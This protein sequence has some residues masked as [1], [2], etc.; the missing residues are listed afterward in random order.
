MQKDLQWVQEKQADRK[1]LKKQNHELQLRLSTMEG[2]LRDA[3][4]KT[5]ALEQSSSR[6]D[7]EAQAQQKEGERVKDRL[8]NAL[9][10]A[11]LQ[12]SVH[13]R[14]AKVACEEADTEL[15]RAGEL[16]AVED[17]HKRRSAAQPFRCL[18]PL[19][20]VSAPPPSPLGA[21]GDASN[22]STSR[23]LRRRRRSSTR[24]SQPMR[25]RRRQQR[26]SRPRPPPPRLAE[27][28]SQADQTARLATQQLESL[29]QLRQS[30]TEKHAKEVLERW[31]LRAQQP[32]HTPHTPPPTTRCASDAK[33]QEPRRCNAR[34]PS[35]RKQRRR[36]PPDLHAAGPSEDE[37]KA[38]EAS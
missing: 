36:P 18:P 31:P 10:E 4:Q 23:S 30:D 27:R 28:L 2:K 20:S 9:R 15:E 17:E 14:L 13:E 21:R 25:S 1:Q 26:R 11:Q 22:S 8:E 38:E 5:S 6:H 37:K 29:R 3:Q 35:S 32:R 24:R 19:P 12:A 7:A 34:A 16:C 33:E